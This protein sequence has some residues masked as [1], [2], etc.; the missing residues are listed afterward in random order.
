MAIN[1]SEDLKIIVKVISVE[2]KTKTD[3]YDTGFPSA[4]Y[5][6]GKD[7]SPTDNVSD[8][9]VTSYK[10]GISLTS[11]TNQIYAIDKL[12]LQ[13]VDDPRTNGTGAI[14][15]YL[16]NSDSNASNITDDGLYTVWPGYSANMVSVVFD[17]NS[18]VTS[19]ATV[20]LT[21][22]VNYPSGVYWKTKIA[23]KVQ[24]VAVKDAVK[25]KSDSLALMEVKM[26]SFANHVTNYGYEP[27]LWDAIRLSERKGVPGF[28]I[29]F[30]FKSTLTTP[31]EL[32]RLL[33]TPNVTSINYST[34]LSYTIDGVDIPVTTDNVDLQFSDGMTLNSYSVTAGQLDMDMKN[35]KLQEYAIEL[36]VFLPYDPGDKDSVT[37]VM[38]GRWNL[39]NDGGVRFNDW[40]NSN[41]ISKTQTGKI[42]AEQ[43]IPLKFTIESYL[44]TN[45]LMAN[46]NGNILTGLIVNNINFLSLSGSQLLILYEDFNGI[47]NIS[48]SPPYL[49]V[50]Y[51]ETTGVNHQYAPP[52]TDYLQQYACVDLSMGYDPTVIARQV[53][54]GSIPVESY[55]DILD[56]G[57]IPNM[58]LTTV[59]VDILAGLNYD[60][61]RE[62]GIYYGN[63]IVE[64][65][66]SAEFLTKYNANPTARFISWAYTVMRIGTNLASIVDANTQY[67]SLLGNGDSFIDRRGK[68]FLDLAT[69]NIEKQNYIDRFN[70]RSIVKKQLEPKP[71]KTNFETAIT[72]DTLLI[73]TNNHFPTITDVYDYT[74][75]YHLC[76][77]M[78]DTRS[79]S[80]ALVVG[81]TQIILAVPPEVLPNIYIIDNP[82]FFNPNPMRTLRGTVTN[83]SLSAEGI[84]I[85]VPSD[86]L[87]D[88]L[89]YLDIPVKFIL[90]SQDKKFSHENTVYDPTKVLLSHPDY[91]IDGFP[92]TTTYY[93]NKLYYINTT[94]KGGAVDFVGLITNKQYYPNGT[95]VEFIATVKNQLNQLNNLYM[96]MTV[97]TNQ[98]NPLI[99]SNNTQ[100]AFIK[101]IVAFDP[102][103]IIYY[104]TASKATSQ[105]IA[106]MKNINQPDTN[107][108][109]YYQNIIINTWTLCNGDRL[110]DDVVMLVAYTP[111]IPQGGIVRVDYVVTVQ[112]ESNTT[113]TYINNAIINYYSSESDIES[114][115]NDVSIQNFNL[116]VPI[117]ITKLPATQQV[118]ACKG[119]ATFDITFTIP[120][121]A[122]GFTS[123]TFTDQL[124]LA[125]S[126]SE[127]STIQIGSNPVQP[128][129]A[130]MDIGTK[131]VSYYFVNLRN[132][133]GQEVQIHL[134]AISENQMNIPENLKD[135]NQAFLI[136]NSDPKKTFAS[137]TVEVLFNYVDEY[138]LN[139]QPLYQNYPRTKG[140]AVPFKIYFDVPMDVEEVYI[141]VIKDTLPNALTYDASNS[142]LQIGTTSVEPLEANVTEQT[143]TVSFDRTKIQTLVGQRVMITIGTTLSDIT[144][145]PE[146]NTV[147][148][149]A[150]LE[151]NNIPA[152]VFNSNSVTASFG[153]P[154]TAIPITKAP[155]M[156]MVT[157][158]VG[159][160]VIFTL[161]FTMPQDVTSYGT[162]TITDVLHPSLTYAVEGS[163]IQFGTNPV[164]PLKATVSSN[165]VQVELEDISPFVGELVT[166]TL[167]ATVNDLSQIPT[168]NQITNSAELMVNHNGMLLSNSN[169]VT[170]TLL[171]WG[172]NSP[173]K[174]ADTNQYQLGQDQEINFEITYFTHTVGSQSMTFKLSDFIDANL[175]VL[176][177]SLDL[178]ETS[179]IKIVDNTNGNDVQITITTSYPIDSALEFPT[180]FKLRIKTKYFA[181]TIEDPNYVIQNSAGIN[182]GSGWVSSN[183]VIIL[184]NSPRKQA[185]S[186]IL[187]S[188]AL[189]Q[190]ALSHILNAEGEKIQAILAMKNVSINTMIQANASV[191][192][193]VKS[194]GKLEMILQGKLEL[195]DCSNCNLR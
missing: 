118:L 75:T 30:Y 155:E 186:D 70:E 94:L 169:N 16:L 85:V 79:S 164:A 69:S 148:N 50:E 17:Q 147:Q 67:G 27:V 15:F 115:S 131:L 20:N 153:T 40:Q 193:M 195:V 46:Y 102:T 190:A 99:N 108:G 111:N 91:I 127:K 167:V 132:L 11:K 185:I 63:P 181:N 176:S 189:E 25:K 19:T 2:T 159:E 31:S 5:L 162:I 135:S 95:S 192:G 172:V 49:V 51:Y 109:L 64:D 128:L 103:T 107:L 22:N 163:T 177:H 136:V 165:I 101:S 41:I 90:S 149:V 83:Y 116:D 180:S 96:S 74:E 161:G 88:D 183:I 100:L 140:E 81:G 9:V 168:S 42:Q 143:I 6:P 36:Q 150:R 106:A 62:I 178:V 3:V 120:E 14:P 156:Q 145:L 184:P 97:P 126:L 144:K 124:P 86:M 57:K 98:Y 117:Q 171:N 24:V 137:N 173:V 182:F 44:K 87:F 56:K 61:N 39:K 166:I 47:S 157:A 170:V 112:M 29:P 1:I 66:S 8:G 146:N 158:A 80:A 84:R 122:V 151:I 45:L 89:T 28:Y 130:S 23:P 7:F 21:L 142:L 93:Q 110:P 4:T 77:Y 26:S 175:K 55:Q 138:H 129:N 141:M 119:E 191:E 13:S 54:D 187:E 65:I 154:P 160:V 48:N 194:I 139:K 59:L 179:Y 105:D 121:D 78:S 174:I 43:I 33:D 18:G 152:F 38:N 71:E 133:A 188:V 134:V 60:P 125:L 52:V 76:F 114:Q 113:K 34:N 82:Q 72:N 58:L 10:L 68:V 12:F 123:L 92:A 35:A 73:M 53:F 37:M 104:Q 32:G